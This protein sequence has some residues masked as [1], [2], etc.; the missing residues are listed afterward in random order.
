MATH[1]L[2][3][4]EKLKAGKSFKKLKINLTTANKKVSHFA[5]AIE[6]SITNNQSLSKNFIEEIHQSAATSV[7]Q[8]SEAIIE[9]YPQLGIAACSEDHPLNQIFRDYFTATQHHIF[10]R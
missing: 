2:S 3:E 5:S 8:I 10:T 4:V 7:K 1:F 6:E 9:V